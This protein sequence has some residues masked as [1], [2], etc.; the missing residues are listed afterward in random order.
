MPTFWELLHQIEGGDGKQF[1]ADQEVIKVASGTKRPLM[2]LPNP[3]SFAIQTVL[4]LPPPVAPLPP[5]EFKKGYRLVLK[6]RT[7]DE[8]YT[9]VPVIRG[10]KQLRQFAPDIVRLQQQEGEEAH[11]ER[12]KWAMRRK[13]SFLSPSEWAKAM[14]KQAKLTIDDQQA[15]MFTDRLDAAY[16]F[17][18]EV[19]KQASA[20][21]GQYN[22]TKHGN[23]WLDMQ[24]TIY[25]CDPDIEL[26]TEGRGLFRKVAKSHQRDRVLHLPE[27]LSQRGLAL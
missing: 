17:D 3:L 5:D 18:M 22:P 25:L 1:S 6:A 19:L 11:I 7:R 12:L 9:G 21:G 2:M 16:Q 15:A 14:L 24:Q 20:R 27:F 13:V 23:D 26:L 10:A 4:R 8:L